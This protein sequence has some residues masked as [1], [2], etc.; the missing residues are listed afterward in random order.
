MVEGVAFSGLWKLM[1]WAP[2]FLLRWFFSK[3]AL[4]SRI[5]MDVR[6]RPYAMQ[7]NGAETSEV[8]VWLS[9]HNNG[10]FPVEIDRVTVSVSIGRTYEFYDLDRVVLAPDATRELHVS[11]ILSPGAVALYKLNKSNNIVSVIIRA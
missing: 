10:Y 1:T 9:I 11:G 5:K 4:K 2:G 7:I 6:N 3:D 8:T